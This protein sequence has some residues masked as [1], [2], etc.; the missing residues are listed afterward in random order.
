MKVTLKGFVPAEVEV[1]QTK[2]KRYQK[3]TKK[4]IPFNL[5]E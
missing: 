5:H 2:T 1:D 3:G 4:I